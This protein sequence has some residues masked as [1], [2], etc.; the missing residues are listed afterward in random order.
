M[1]IQQNWHREAGN[2]D[3]HKNGYFEQKKPFPRSVAATQAKYL[4]CNPLK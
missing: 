1:W 3:Q 2:K 4:M